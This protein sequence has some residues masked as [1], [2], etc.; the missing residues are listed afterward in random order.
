MVGESCGKKIVRGGGRGESWSSSREFLHSERL[1]NENG[2]LRIWGW[3]LSA[4]QPTDQ[5]EGRVFRL[6]TVGEGLFFY[7]PCTVFWGA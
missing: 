5:G 6:V 1:Q 3:F 4:A 2:W 7:F